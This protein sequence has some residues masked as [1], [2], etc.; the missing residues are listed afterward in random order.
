M[1]LAGKN[2]EG[3]G[4]RREWDAGGGG[5]GAAV[6]FIGTTDLG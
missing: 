6:T 5:G 4:R 2:F 3:G 1:G